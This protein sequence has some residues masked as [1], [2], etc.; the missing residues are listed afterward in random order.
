MRVICTTLTC[1]PSTQ[2][3]MNSV[4]VSKQPWRPFLSLIVTWRVWEFGL[5]ANFGTD[6]RE[7]NAALH[8]GPFSLWLGIAK[9]RW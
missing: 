9:D 4:P 2:G 8:V 6:G 3:A 7:W 5:G 1:W